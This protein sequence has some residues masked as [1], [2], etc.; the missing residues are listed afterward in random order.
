MYDLV[1]MQ[2][3]AKSALQQKRKEKNARYY[4]SNRTAML[5]RKAEYDSQHRPK[6]RQKDA[7]YHKEHRTEILQKKAEYDS[8]HRSEKNT[9]ANTLRNFRS[10]NQDMAGHIKEFRLSQRDGLSYTCASC[11]RLWFKSSVV[12]VASKRS[13][14]GPEILEPLKVHKNDTLLSTYLCNGEDIFSDKFV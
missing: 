8:Q 5:K 12:D 6:K 3:E 10:K 13:K 9:A 11:C 14:M 1:L 2:A 7:D 4:E